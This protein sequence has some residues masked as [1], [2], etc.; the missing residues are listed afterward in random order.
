MSQQK[1]PL[2]IYQKPSI[3][4]IIIIIILTSMLF[5]PFIYA[6]NTKQAI[7]FLLSIVGLICF[8]IFNIITKNKFL[9]SGI[10]KKDMLVSFSESGLEI[11]ENQ[12]NIIHQWNNLEKIKISIYA[13]DGKMYGKQKSYYG[14]ENSIQFIENGQKFKYR[15]YIE[16]VNQFKSLKEQFHTTILPLLNQYQ[17]LNEE[18]YFEIT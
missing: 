12:E 1:F 10:I 18:S 6:V 2:A 14:Y 3:I 4:E 8:K 13:Y 16:N 5:I 9:P 7:Y 15:F 17:N 11:N